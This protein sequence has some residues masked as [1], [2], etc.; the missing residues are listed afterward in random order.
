MAE[1]RRQDIAKGI[2]SKRK[3]ECRQIP[4]EAESVILWERRKGNA[5]HVGKENRRK[6]LF[7]SQI[8]D[9]RTGGK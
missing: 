5:R 2:R 6:F 9:T 7:F 4:N 8:F 1:D 3:C